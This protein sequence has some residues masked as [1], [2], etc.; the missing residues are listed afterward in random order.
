MKIYQQYPLLRKIVYSSNII[1]Q[2]KHKECWENIEMHDY[3]IL[4]NIA[5][6]QSVQ[7][8]EREIKKYYEKNIFV[9]TFSDN[10]FKF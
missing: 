5:H 7:V 1:Y 10:D 2:Y 3:Y 6:T 9:H 4:E 8:L